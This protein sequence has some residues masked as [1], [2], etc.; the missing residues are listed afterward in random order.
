MTHNKMRTKQW[1]AEPIG[2][3]AEQ[4]GLDFKGKWAIEIPKILFELPPPGFNFK[5]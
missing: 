5:F 2:F 4:M 3:I 1:V